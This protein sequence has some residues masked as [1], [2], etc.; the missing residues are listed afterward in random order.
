MEET[1]SEVDTGNISGDV[2]DQFAIGV[3]MPSA[4]GQCK[5]L[6]VDRSDQPRAHQDTGT[7]GTVE[8]VMKSQRRHNLKEEETKREA[9]AILDGRSCPSGTVGGIGMLGEPDNGLIEM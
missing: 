2:V 5:G 4:S 7:H 6:V 9:N 8:G 3:D 1:A